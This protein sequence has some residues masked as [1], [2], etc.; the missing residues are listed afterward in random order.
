MLA[1]AGLERMGL[2]GRIR[3]HFSMD[4]MLPAVGQGALAVECRADDTRTCVLLAP[5]DDAPT[6]AAVSA[7]R[8]FLRGLG[9][10]CT[11]PIGAYAE[12]DAGQLTVHG[13]IAQPD[14]QKIVRG[15]LSGSMGDAETMGAE[16]AERLMAEGGAMLLEALH[17]ANPSA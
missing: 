1:A 15:M 17:A 4:Q 12:S 16:L 6:R 10:G 14:G 8:A 3:E 11:L 7:E 2:A 5:L 9:G 13:L